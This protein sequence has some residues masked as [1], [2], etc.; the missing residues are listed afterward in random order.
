MTASAK[1]LIPGSSP[2][3][4]QFMMTDSAQPDK[5][6]LQTE[7]DAAPVIEEATHLRHQIEAASKRDKDYRV[8]GVIPTAVYFEGIRKGYTS[9]DFAEYLRRNPALQ[10]EGQYVRKAL[11]AG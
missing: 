11:R 6:F 4:R 3:V 5:V 8:L 2:H 9:E 1:F 10:V 7:F